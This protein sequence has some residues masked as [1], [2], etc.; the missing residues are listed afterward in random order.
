MTWQEFWLTASE[1][2]GPALL[3]IAG[4][5]AVGAAALR[6]QTAQPVHG[7]LS[8]IVA[9]AAVGV[10]SGVAAGNS[11]DPVVGAVLP[12]MLTLVSG[13][14]VY[15]FSKDGLAQWR[16]VIPFCVAV[17]AIGGLVGLSLGSTLRSQFDNF[18]REYAKALLRYERV[19]LEAQKAEYLAKLEVWKQRQMNQAPS[20]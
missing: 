3:A 11:R 10:T 13:L 4:L 20:D 1:I 9:F 2:L 16:P 6:V 14:F 8:L 12:A 17:V 18:E 7:S 15:M 19:E 5:A